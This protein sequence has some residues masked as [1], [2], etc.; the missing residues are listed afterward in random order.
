M[1][2]TSKDRESC[3][4]HLSEDG[5]SVI[6]LDQRKLPN[7]QEYLE[8]RTAGEMYDAIKTHS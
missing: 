5:R 4:V 1:T 2:I 3:S 6:I 8:L 7:R